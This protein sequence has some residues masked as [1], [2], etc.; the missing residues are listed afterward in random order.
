MHSFI[1]RPL[2]VTKCMLDDGPETAYLDTDMKG[3][4]E[5]HCNANTYSA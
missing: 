1:Y 3:N 2:V 5:C 4:C